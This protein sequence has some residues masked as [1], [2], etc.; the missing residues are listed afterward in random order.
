MRDK[1]GQNSCCIRLPLLGLELR[2]RQSPTT[3]ETLEFSSAELAQLC[4]DLTEVAKPPLGIP[5][6]F[7]QAK[8]TLLDLGL[9]APVGGTRIRPLW[10]IAGP[11]P[12]WLARNQRSTW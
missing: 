7:E 6:G 11:P 12:P 4:H 2:R 8:S 10:Y 9:L 1:G 5:C 3:R